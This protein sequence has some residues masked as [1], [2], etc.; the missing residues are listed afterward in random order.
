MAAPYY[1]NLELPFKEG[2]LVKLEVETPSQGKFYC[3]SNNKE[4]I[5]FKVDT[6]KKDVPEGRFRA[7]LSAPVGSSVLAN[8]YDYVLKMDFF[9]VKNYNFIGILDCAPNWNRNLPGAG[10]KAKVIA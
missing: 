10:F 3:L 5:I 1:M 8:Q 7:I 9:K 4:E 6:I 2:D